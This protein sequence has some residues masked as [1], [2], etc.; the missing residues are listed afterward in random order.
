MAVWDDVIS[1]SDRRIFAAAG[2]G[3]RAGFG[4]RPA[5]MVIDVNYNFCGD[6]REPILESIKR[7]HFLVRRTRVGCHRRHP[8]DSHRGAPQAAAGDLHNESAPRGRLRSGHLVAQG[9]AFG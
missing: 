9:H 7:W 4:K 3:R 1:E 8:Q 6:K 5:I 2:W